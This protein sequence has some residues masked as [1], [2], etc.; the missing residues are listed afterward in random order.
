M[1][2]II[3]HLSTIQKKNHR[4]GSGENYSDFYYSDHNMF[5]RRNFKI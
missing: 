1:V 4:K 5:M 2:V 3:M